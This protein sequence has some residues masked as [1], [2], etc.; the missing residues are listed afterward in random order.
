MGF[1]SSGC[2]VRVVCDRGDAWLDIASRHT[3]FVG[4]V[5]TGWQDL[6]WN[7]RQQGIDAAYDAA[8]WNWDGTPFEQLNPSADHL[9]Q[10]L[11]HIAALVYPYATCLSRLCKID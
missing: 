8:A 7:M 9:A 3:P 11:H 1:E 5:R 4:G 2:R 6:V 10:Q